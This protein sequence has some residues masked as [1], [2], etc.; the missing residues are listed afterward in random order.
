MNNQ[1]KSYSIVTE[2]PDTMA[3]EEQIRRLYTRYKFAASYSVGKDILE[4]ACGAGQGLGYIARVSKSVVGI[5]VDDTNL[6]YA[7]KQYADR[8]QIKLLKADAHNLPFTDNSFDLIIIYEAIYYLNDPLKFLHEAKR[9]LRKDGIIIIGSANKE[10]E[11][12]NP[13]VYSVRYYTAS[14]LAEM[15]KSEDKFTDIKIYVDCPVRKSDL[16]DKIISLIKVLAVKLKLIPKTMKGKE[17]LKRFF[18]GKLKPLPSEITDDMGVTYTQP[19]IYE[20]TSQK[21]DNYK[22]IFAVAKVN[23]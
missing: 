8:P 4:V 12:F 14:E 20:N 18:M 1:Q 22:V 5:D 13:S 16:R 17:L 23:K 6:S 19:V 15:L 10:W 3:P 7:R 9:V 11:G 2:T 21:C